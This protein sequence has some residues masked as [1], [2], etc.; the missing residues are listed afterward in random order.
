MIF[1]NWRN[2]AYLSLSSLYGNDP[3][4]GIYY[5]ADIYDRALDSA[6][7]VQNYSLGIS[8]T[9]YPFIIQEPQ[10]N[11]LLKVFQVHLVLRQL[12]ILLYLINGKKME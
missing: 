2:D 10:T 11:K 3:Y 5:L 12:G 1:S 6:E 4:E 7:V 8:G 9:N